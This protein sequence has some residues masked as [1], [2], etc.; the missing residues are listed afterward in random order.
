MTKRV[1][2]IP[3]FRHP[4]RGMTLVEVIVVMII[5]T[6]LIM[7]SA[8]G[9]GLFLRKYKELN[10]WAELQKEAWECLSTIK[11]GVPVGT[12]LNTEF[13]GVTNALQLR[14]MNTA[15]N[16]GTYLR[17]TP[18]TDRGLNTSDYALF[19]LYDGAVRC[20]YLHKGYQPATP[21]YL[22]P[23]KK[24]KDKIVVDKFLITKINREQDLLAIQVE[25][26]GSVKTGTNSFRK[27]K[28]KTKMVKK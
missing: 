8:L 26:E 7:I 21:L 24:N 10:A 9:I 16:S 25:L 1:K 19:Y 14:L 28:F 6:L 4:E 22:F 18:P 27:V 13:I 2:P 23:T 11:N 17:I 3:G 12:G 5:S 15:T 20:S